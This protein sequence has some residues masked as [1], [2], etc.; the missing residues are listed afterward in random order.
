VDFGLGFHLI[1]KQVIR[2]LV[3][4]R[5]VPDEY[6]TWISE[7]ECHNELWSKSRFVFEEEL[8]VDRDVGHGVATFDNF[9]DCCPGPIHAWTVAMQLTA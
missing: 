3:R 4:R 7:P 2:I 1:E 8:I 6:S 5:V 9:H